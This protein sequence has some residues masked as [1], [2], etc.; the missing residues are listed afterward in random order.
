MSEA[1]EAQFNIALP[2]RLWTPAELCGQQH[3]QE[4]AGAE[5]GHHV[6]GEP[7]GGFGGL[8]PRRHGLGHAIDGRLRFRTCRHRSHRTA[9]I[10]RIRQPI[11]TGAARTRRCSPA[12]A[13]A[14]CAGPVPGA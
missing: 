8:G 9:T 1:L 7:A 12:T 5:V 10:L 6:V 11:R 3:A 4:A 14:T 2:T 13:D